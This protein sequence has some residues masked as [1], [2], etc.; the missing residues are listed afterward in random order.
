MEIRPDFRAAEPLLQRLAGIG[1]AFATFDNED[2]PHLKNREDFQR[3]YLLPYPQKEKLEE[4]YAKGRD[5]AIFMGDHLRAFNDVA[6][7]PLFSDYVDSFSRTWAYED[8]DLRLFLEQ[9]RELAAT[10]PQTPWAVSRMID[11]FEQQLR[12]LGAVRHTVALLK[13][14]HPYLV[15]IGKAPMD[16]PNT[17]TIGSVTGKVNIN[18]TDNSTN[19][20]FNSSPVFHELAAA[21]SASTIEPRDKAKLLHDVEQMKETEGT[22]SFTEKYKLFIQNAANHMAVITP[23]LPALAAVLP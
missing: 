2:W 11:L 14:S 21:I 18:S 8:E 23:F 12:L 10:L 20:T 5:C 7:F 1:A 3:V 4:L 15:D 13:D 9:V 17:I 6:K 19:Y 22:T 16:K